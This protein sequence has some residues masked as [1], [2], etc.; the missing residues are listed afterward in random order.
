MKNVINLLPDNIANQI[1]AGEVIQRPAS[2]VKELV[3]NSIDA[4]ATEIIIE[5]L[6]GG[7]TLLKIIDNGIG[8]SSIDARMAFER[9]ATSKIKTAEDLFDLHTMGFRGEA[10][11]SIAAVAQVEL[12]TREKGEEL[13]TKLELLRGEVLVN[14]VATCPEGS[15]F[16]IKN[17]FHDLPARRKFLKSKETE[18]KRI[19]DEIYRI[20]AVNP[21]ISFKLYHQKKIVSDYPK[22]NL[23][24]RLLDLFGQR[25]SDRLLSLNVKSPLVEIKG[26][27]TT[28]LYSKKRGAD[29][30]FFVNN[31]F[32]RHSYFHRVIMNAYEGI[33]PT[34]EKPEYFIYFTVDPSSID[35]NIHPTKTEIKFENESYIGQILYTVVRE[36]IMKGTVA[37]SIDFN[38]KNNI[39]IPNYKPLDEDELVEPSIGGEESDFIPS[40]NPN[41]YTD[42]SQFIDDDK[43]WADFYRQFELDAGINAGNTSNNK[44]ATTITSSLNNKIATKKFELPHSTITS[45]DSKNIKSNISQKNLIDNTHVISKSDAK[46]LLISNKYLVTAHGNNLIFVDIYQAQR[47]LLYYKYTAILNSSNPIS[48]PLLFPELIDLT[49]K[50]IET[51][52]TF[53]SELNNLGFVISDMGGNSFVLSSVPEGIPASADVFISI[54]S[55][56]ESIDKNITEIVQEK[57]IG[58]LIKSLLSKKADRIDDKQSQK[59][60]EELFSLP[61][62]RYTFDGK[63]IIYTLTQK[64]IDKMFN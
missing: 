28:P 4:N 62:Y 25:L 32:M 7:K 22:T 54:L 55:E 60:I 64:D 40:F 38:T 1:A 57:I 34:G 39:E 48:Q 58:I 10:L 63:K 31:R 50:E 16:S 19:Q 18:F 43:A 21:N 2:V 35:V 23:K 5:I 12:L 36:V 53:A 11:P 29:Q 51:Y 44:Q 20:A 52:K 30:F 8:M 59:I 37:S 46:T 49:A 45:I 27:I 61:E 24:Q 9:H 33:I 56:C 41:D 17:I 6:D 14:E 42:N 26:Y 13:G 47:A 15:I 3:E